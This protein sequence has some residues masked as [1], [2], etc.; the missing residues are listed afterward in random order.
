MLGRKAE[1]ER[2]VLTCS[3]NGKDY[4]GESFLFL[5]LSGFRGLDSG[6]QSFIVSVLDSEPSS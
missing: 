1:S 2:E 4:L 6:H 3:W 5:P